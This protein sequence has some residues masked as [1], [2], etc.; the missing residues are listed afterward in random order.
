MKSLATFLLTVV[1]ITVAGYTFA[2]PN[3]SGKT[4]TTELVEPH[5]SGFNSIKIAGPFTVHLIQG[6]AESVKIEV[7]DD[8]KGRITAK[9]TGGIL[10]IH[11]THDNW[12]QGYKSWYSDKSVWRNHKKIVVYITAKDLKR[13]SISGSGNVTFDEGITANSLKLRVRGSGNMLGKIEVKTLKSHISGSGSMKL[14]GAAENSTVRVVGS[15]NFTARD[16]VTLNSAVHVSGSGKAEVNA[17]EKV[18]AA[19]YGSGDVRYTGTVKVVKK[20]K[21]GSGEINRF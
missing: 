14:S 12:S 8:V 18:N 16:L 1:L 17:S 5:L 9:V 15:G 13:I 3:P 7:P 4:D 19:V 6:P 11:N 2:K 20:T 21:S 10:K